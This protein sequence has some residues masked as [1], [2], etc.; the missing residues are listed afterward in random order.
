MDPRRWYAG[1]LPSGERPT[2]PAVRGDPPGSM[3]RR[4]DLWQVGNVKDLQL[5]SA[6]VDPV[7]ILDQARLNCV[8]GA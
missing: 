5:V 7:G 2:R 6:G 8:V 4:H 3:L 1:G